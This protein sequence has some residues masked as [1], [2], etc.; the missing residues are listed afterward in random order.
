VTEAFLVIHS[1]GG[2][3]EHAPAYYAAFP[4]EPSPFGILTFTAAR[5]VSMD[6][7]AASL[8]LALN[9]LV[10]AGSGAAVLVCH[11]FKSGLLLPVAPGGGSVFAT[12]DT[13][14]TIDKLTVFDVTHDQIRAMP[15]TNDDERKAVV[16]R[17]GPFYTSLGWPPG[18]T[19][20]PLPADFT[21]LQAERVYQQWFSSWMTRLE[22]R[23]PADLRELFKRVKTMRAAHL[24]RLELRACNIGGDAATM[25]RVRTFFGCNKLTAPTKGTFFGFVPVSPL[26]VVR[27]PRG[28]HGPTASAIPLGHNDARDA[29][30]SSGLVARTDTTRGFLFFSSVLSIPDS[31]QQRL[32]RFVTPFFDDSSGIEL[33][34]GFRFVLRI[35]EVRAFHYTIQ[36]WAA[37]SSRAPS[38]DP[39]IIRQFC[40]D[41]FKAGTNFRATNLPIAGLWTPGSAKPF[42]L[43]LETEYLQLIAQSPTPTPKKP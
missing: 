33:F 27:R 37:G 22:F 7:G 16:T 12:I 20:L 15:Q 19:P 4:Q 38:P 40:G 26:D 39:D 32:P 29:T 24:D 35:T 23:N 28:T 30:V 1:G 17:W 41:V 11:A 18:A 14:D 5:T 13:M 6:A 25:D 10:K 2:G 21:D 42:V 8:F 31:S 34:H 3:L 43:P 36:A 9:E